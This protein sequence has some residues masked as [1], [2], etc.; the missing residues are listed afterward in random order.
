MS[1]IAISIYWYYHILSNL[2]SNELDPKVLEFLKLLNICV[3]DSDGYKRN[4]ENIK[5]EFK[6]KIYVI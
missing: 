6:S 3:F 1:K 5:R 4:I 2:E